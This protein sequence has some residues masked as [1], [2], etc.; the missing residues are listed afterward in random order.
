MTNYWIIESSGESRQVWGP[1]T[2]LAA[3][4][5]AAGMRHTVITGSGLESGMTMTRGALNAALTSGRINPADGADR[6][7]L[8]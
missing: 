6:D 1:Y 7:A 5:H 2:S 3:A 4:K 8:A